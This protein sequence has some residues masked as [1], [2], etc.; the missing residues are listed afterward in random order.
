M[1]KVPMDTAMPTPKAPA[2]IDANATV[3]NNTLPPS[4]S[5]SFANGN[6]S[7][8]IAGPDTVLVRAEDGQGVGRFFGL[9]A[10]SDSM[11]AEI[12]YNIK[13]WGNNATQL[14]TYQIPVGTRGFFGQVEGGSGMQ[15]F[16]PGAQ[17]MPGIQLIDQTTLFTSELKYISPALKP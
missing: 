3:A 12:M 1:A 5:S 15:V 2:L 13:A 10:P 9:T 14:S 11:D 17:T 6:A 4:V 8:W 16:I 7:P